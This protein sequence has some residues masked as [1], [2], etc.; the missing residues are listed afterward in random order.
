MN[1]HVLPKVSFLISPVVGTAIIH[2]TIVVG[3]SRKKID[4]EKGKII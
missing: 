4:N 1:G 3:T 2:N